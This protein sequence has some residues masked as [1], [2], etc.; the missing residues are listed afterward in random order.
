MTWRLGF[1]P[2]RSCIT[3]VLQ[4]SIIALSSQRSIITLGA[5][6]RYPMYAWCRTTE[7]AEAWRCHGEPLLVHFSRSD[8]MIRS[9]QYLA[10]TS[11]SIRF[12]ARAS[13][14]LNVEF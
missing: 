8:L 5:D 12:L 10:C 3:Y 4:A 6:T 13:R 11:K 7:A 9:Q 2:S 1:T 14:L